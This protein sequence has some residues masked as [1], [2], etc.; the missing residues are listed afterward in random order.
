MLRVSAVSG[1]RFGLP[2]IRAVHCPAGH[3]R[4]LLNT[5]PA[6]TPVASQRPFVVVYPSAE[7]LRS[8]HG[9][10]PEFADTPCAE[11]NSLMFG[12]RTA[13]SN[14]ARKR[15]SSVGAHS[16]LYLYEL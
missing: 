11:N 9:S 2:P 4:P 3:S 15:T 12:A 6:G 8:E 7:P 16:P 13:F 14:E 1:A 10:L 5:E